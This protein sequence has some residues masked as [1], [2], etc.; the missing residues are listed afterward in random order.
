LAVCLVKSLRSPTGY[1]IVSLAFA[2]LIVGMVVMPLN[3]LFEM[4]GHVWLL[5][6]TMC[7]VF[8]AMD[9][10][11]STSSIWSLC[12]IA[13][14]R[15]IAGRDPLQYRNKISKRRISVAISLIWLFSAS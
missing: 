11:A 3:G 1:F 2:D 5:G 6:S 8:H 4:T 7:D 14:D 12:V 9:I 15:Y 13:V 10:L